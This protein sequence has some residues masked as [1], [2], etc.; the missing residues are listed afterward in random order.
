M[1]PQATCSGLLVFEQAADVRGAVYPAY[2]ARCVGSG[3]TVSPG[4]E[5]ALDEH[6]A[7]RELAPEHR[8]AQIWS[9]RCLGWSQ[10]AVGQVRGV[11]SQN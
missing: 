2:R 7:A 4:E 10:Y 5:R 9:Y 3:A 8:A 1:A 6:H 11:A